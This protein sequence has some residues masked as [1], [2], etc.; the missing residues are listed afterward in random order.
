MDDIL[1]HHGVKGMRWGVRK[2]RSNRGNAFRERWKQQQEAKKLKSKGKSKVKKETDDEQEDYS[3]LDDN[4]LRQRINRIKMEKEYA[5]LTATPKQD[6][7]PLV[8]RGKK[9][10]QDIL[11][12]GVKKGA[13]KGLASVV[14]DSIKALS[15]G[16]KPKN[17]KKKM[18][19]ETL[20]GVGKKAGEKAGKAA[21]KAA[22]KAGKKVKEKTKDAYKNSTT[23]VAP[24]KR[25]TGVGPYNQRSRP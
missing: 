14:E 25:K 18:V 1:E 16:E 7:H 10:A 21:K 8:T 12:D 19:E 3:N 13:T 24:Y 22:K 9:T 17:P 4:E 20:K 11:F 5:S 6:K 23:T 15:K 2:D